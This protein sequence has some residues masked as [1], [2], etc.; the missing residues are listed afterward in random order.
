M[1]RRPR[2]PPAAALR[3]AV[4]LG[5]ADALGVTRD[6]LS[7]PRWHRFGPGVRAH[8]SLDPTDPDLRIAALL[9]GLPAGAVLGGWASLHLQRVPWQDGRTGLGGA[10][11][12]PFLVHVGPTGHLR[13]RLG[14]VVDRSRLPDADVVEVRGT[15]ATAVTRAVFDEMCR[16]GVEDGM[17]AGDAACAVRLTSR[18]EM[19]SYVAAHPRARGI[20]AARR[21]AALL[22]PYVRSAPESRL[23]YVWVVE[24][25]LPPPEVNIA[26][27]D[28]RGIVLGEPDLLDRE[29]GLVGEYD[30]ADHRTLAR[31]TADNAREEGFERNNLTVVRATSVDLWPRRRALVSRVLDGRAR[32]LARDR[33]R[34]GWWIQVRAA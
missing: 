25:G 3:G 32:G 23:R 4:R 5:E 27:A 9:Q 22:S 18:D 17:V 8:G 33:T 26:L 28:A 13:Q 34:D 12:R 16:G 15:K 31:H 2:I 7:S 14:L 11:L 20:P 1:P 10:K 24:A 21:A 30:G 19:M 29:A 6:E